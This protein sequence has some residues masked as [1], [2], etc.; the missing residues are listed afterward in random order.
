[1]TNQTVFIC[2]LLSIFSLGSCSFHE[3]ESQT[4]YGTESFVEIGEIHKPTGKIFG[5]IPT[6]KLPEAS[7]LVTSKRYPGYLWTLNDSGSKPRLFLINES[8]IIRGQVTLKNIENRDWEDIALYEDPISRIS[9]ILIGEI[10]DNKAKHSSVFVHKIA[11]PFLDLRQESIQKTKIDKALITSYEFVYP[12]GPRDAECLMIDPINSSII[13][14]SKREKEVGVYQGFMTEKEEVT[15]LLKINTLKTTQVTAGDISAD[16]QYILIK[17][18]PN[19]FLWKRRQPKENLSE[20]FSRPPM[21]MPYIVEPQG[22]AIAWKR[23]RSGYFTVSESED[24]AKAP[25]YFYSLVKNEI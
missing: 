20:T 3:K 6:Q 4:L 19:V 13:I 12:Q 16:G 2:L 22:E 9:Y 25:L 15:T 21:K 11:E 7:G 18:Y 23:D 10:G 14:V 1:M 17:T 24:G 8:G 5:Y